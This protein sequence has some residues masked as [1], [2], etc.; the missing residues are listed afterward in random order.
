MS[1]PLLILAGI[2]AKS[3]G[4]KAD[5]ELAYPGWECKRIDATGKD[6]DL[7]YCWDRVL[8][9]IAHHEEHEDAGIHVLAF[10]KPESDYPEFKKQVAPYHRIVLLSTTLLSHFGRDM[11]AF[12]A[13]LDERVSF[14]EAWRQH[15]L[16]TMLSAPLLLPKEHFAI[17]GRYKQIW[18]EATDLHDDVNALFILGKT[19]RQF[20]IDQSGEVGS[21]AGKQVGYKD[22]KKRLFTYNGARHG[23][24]WEDGRL[25]LR[26]KFNYKMDEGFHYD[27]V[28]IDGRPMYFKSDGVEREFHGHVNVYPH[29]FIRP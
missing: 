16:P 29:G 23:R 10:H 25:C 28:P 18:G 14:E 13:A 27:V 20:E 6:V 22:D 5:Y 26:W 9:T 17:P 7:Q 12:R 3:T 1:L 4:R 8:A 11:E 24:I 15:V 2:P 19:I 21:G